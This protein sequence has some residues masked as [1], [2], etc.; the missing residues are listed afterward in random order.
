MRN[1]LLALFAFLLLLSVGCSSTPERNQ[2]DRP[3]LEVDPGVRY[4]L[5]VTELFQERMAQPSG[6]RLL[7]VQ[8]AVAAHA[9]MKFGWKINWF[10]REGMEVSGVG[11]GYRRVRVLPDQTRYFDA[12]APN[13]SVESFQLHLRETH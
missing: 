5:T 6:D 8:F 12:V 3:E 2:V 7:R 9:D 10:D 4:G 13:P 1:G 11:E